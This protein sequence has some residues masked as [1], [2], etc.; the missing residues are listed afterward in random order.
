M[1]NPPARSL[2]SLSGQHSRALDELGQ[3]I[4]SGELAAGTSLTLEAIEER[5]GISRSVARETVRVLESMRLV[6]S[7]RRVGVVI[8]GESDW[9]LYDP[10]VIRW[11]LNSPDRAHQLGLLVELRAAIEPEAARLA[12]THATSEQVSGLIALSGQLWAAG[13]QGDH[14]R[15]LELDVQFHS[16]VLELSGNAMFSRLDQLVGQVLISRT[17]HGLVP[18]RPAADALQRHVDVAGAI[19][20][21][22]PDAA[23]ETM[24]SILATARHEIDFLSL[25]ADAESD[26]QDRPTSA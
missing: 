15:F 16:M 26:P 5:C 18:D 23:Y 9:N 17:E 4:C 6:A 2:V 13:E 24:R 8:L 1:S 11:R 12:A 7:R 19:Q 14:E 10:Q 22:N 3:L 25:T 21:R 20:R